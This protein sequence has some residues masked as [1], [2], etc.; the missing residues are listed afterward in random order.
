MPKPIRK[1]KQS[2]LKVCILV[3]AMCALLLMPLGVLKRTWFMLVIC[4]LWHGPAVTFPNPNNIYL[5]GRLVA[6]TIVKS[7]ETKE[8]ALKLF[9]TALG[10]A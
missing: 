1:T 5:G 2:D 4:I 10:P 3:W 6:R 9:G 8:H 7:T